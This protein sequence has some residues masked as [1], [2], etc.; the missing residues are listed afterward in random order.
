MGW[1]VGRG[2]GWGV[3]WDVGWGVG[4][5][6]GW[7]VGRGAGWGVGWGAP[8]VQPCHVS[9][10]CVRSDDEQRVVRRVRGE[11]VERC[12]EEALLVRAGLG[13]WLG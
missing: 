3:G 6:A 12:L 5:G 8:E 10:R 11:A 4:W 2:V 1:G 9:D 13:L 7:G